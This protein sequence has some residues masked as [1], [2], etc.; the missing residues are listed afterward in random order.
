[1]GSRAF[2]AA[3]LLLWLGAMTWLF[4]TKIIPSRI[5]A[6]TPGHATLFPPGDLSDVEPVS[7]EILWNDQRIGQASTDWENTDAGKVIR[8]N[9]RF[10][11]LPLDEMV[12]S[13]L[14]P[15]QSLIPA[16]VSRD[17]PNDWEFEVRSEILFSEANKPISLLSHVRLD[18]FSE[19]IELRGVF[20]GKHLSVTVS[21][22]P[23]DGSRAADLTELFKS[24][25]S[26]PQDAVVADL[27]SPLAQFRRLRLGQSW[28]FHAYRPSSLMS[29][30]QLV[31]GD[32]V[33]REIIE[34]HGQ[35]VSALRVSFRELNSLSAASDPFSHLWVQ[36]DG[37][38]LRQEL[39]MG[40]TRIEFVRS[41]SSRPIRD[42]E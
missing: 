41:V 11:H 17:M 15:V 18:E 42:N 28:R 12:R 23:T 7:W 33:G 2:Q 4:V 20:Q 27:F 39:V 8:G 34:Y 31:Q 19:M 13:L 30:I 3:V 32:V 1:M 24:R 14:G 37:M 10:E 6:E 22:R 35:Q 25:F 21:S 26:I 36:D 38:V 5:S 9:V 16:S 29:P 40:T